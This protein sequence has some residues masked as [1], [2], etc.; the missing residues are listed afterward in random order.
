MD[1]ITREGNLCGGCKPSRH[2]ARSKDAAREAKMK[3]LENLKQDVSY[4]WPL[5]GGDRFHKFTGHARKENL[6]S[7]WSGKIVRHEKLLAETFSERNTVSKTK[8][9]VSFPVPENKAIHCV[10]LNDNSLRIVT[11]PAGNG[12]EKIHD[13]MPDFV[14]IE[15]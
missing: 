10:I 14:D 11:Q 1:G 5:Q 8:E 4:T 3:A 9:L 13:R 12:V 15:G 6:D 7:V 2:T